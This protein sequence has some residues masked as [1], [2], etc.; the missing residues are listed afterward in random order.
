MMEEIYLRDKRSLIRLGGLRRV[1]QDNDGVVLYYHEPGTS[2]RLVCKDAK[3]A[4]ELLNVVTDVAHQGQGGVVWLGPYLK[5]DDAPPEMPVE[6]EKAP[7]AEPKKAAWRGKT[8][9]GRQAEEAGG[10]S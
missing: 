10:T 1:T 6:E 4:A 2:Q 3:A 5:E 9:S 8:P 7:P